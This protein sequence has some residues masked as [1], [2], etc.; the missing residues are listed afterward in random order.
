MSRIAPAAPERLD[1]ATDST[2]SHLRARL[3]KVPNAFATLAQA[4][5]ALDG[6]LALSKSLARGHL[7]ARQR[8]ALALAIAQANECQYCLSAHTSSAKAAGLTPAEIRKARYVQ[9]D[10]PFEKALTAFA[11]SVVRH[12]GQV[13]E[14]EFA[15]ARAGGIGDVLMLEIVALVSLHTLMNY[16]NRLADTEI[17][18]PVVQVQP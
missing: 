16:T 14:I 6:Y 7:N 12:R 4:P 11:V 13:P 3:G 1:A 18:F 2:L 5:A 9:S 15:A 17:D 10:D 8:E